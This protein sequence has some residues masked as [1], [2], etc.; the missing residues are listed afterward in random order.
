MSSLRA[1]KRLGSRDL[2]K[3]KALVH[4]ICSKCPDKNLLGA[5]KL[6]K[7]LW[8]ADAISL[9]TRGIS[10]T[11]ETYVKRQFGPVPKHILQVIEK[12]EDE[13]KIAVKNTPFHNYEKREFVSLKEPNLS[14]FT[15]DEISLV[16]DVIREICF[17]HTA[18]SISLASHDRIWELAEIGDEL[19]LETIFASDLDEVTEADVRWA[20]RALSKIA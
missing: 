4:Y 6:N 19:P 17:N 15:P 11:K 20:K 8:Y 13:D 16:D 10:I 7:I 3:L 9:E 5:T 2:K 12:L 1:H 14:V 18:S